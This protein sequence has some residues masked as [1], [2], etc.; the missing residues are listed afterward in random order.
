MPLIIFNILNS[1][2]WIYFSEDADGKPVIPRACIVDSKDR[3]ITEVRGIL[4]DKNSKQHLDSYIT[5]VVEEKLKT[6]PSGKKW[7]T[8]M[9][10]MKKLASIHL[11]YLRNEPLDKTDLRFL[12]EIDR[13]I[14]SSG[15]EKDPRIAQILKHRDIKADLSFVLN[16]P[17]EKIS[18]TQ[19][20][21][22]SGDIIYHYGNLNLDSLILAKGLTLPKSVGGYLYLGSLT[23]AEKEKLKRDYPHLANKII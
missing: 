19:E 3:G 13:P 9:E 16:V 22:L 15:Y 12:Y 23:S 5:P 21:A 14:K 11:K 10:D 18:I 2:L 6:L 4:S 1:D 17:K 20:E 7:K 8:T